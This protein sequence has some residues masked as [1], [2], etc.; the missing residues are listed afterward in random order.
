MEQ[1]ASEQQK[2]VEVDEESK[3]VGPKVT[4]TAETSVLQDEEPLP[5]SPHAPSPVPPAMEEEIP[6]APAV[7]MSLVSVGFNIKTL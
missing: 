5:Q 2:D 4:D 6:E 3:E 1:V 7:D